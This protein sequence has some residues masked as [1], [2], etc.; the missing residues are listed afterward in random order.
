MQAE[1]AAVDTTMKPGIDL[2]G[3]GR[4]QA[5]QATDL[6]QMSILEY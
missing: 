4:G 2:V 5:R 3:R 6:L 1:S